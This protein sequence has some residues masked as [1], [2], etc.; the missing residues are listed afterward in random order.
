MRSL[1]ILTFVVIALGLPF[2]SGQTPTSEVSVVATAGEDKPAAVPPLPA[3][4]AAKL[5]ARVEKMEKDFEQQKR[6]VLTSAIARLSTAAGSDLAA[7]DLYLGCRRILAARSAAAQEAIATKKPD[8]KDA[9]AMDKREEQLRD[10]LEEPGHG[11]VLRLQAEYLM[12]TLEAPAAKD[13]AALVGRVR[14]FVNKAMGI[15]RLSISAPMAAGGNKVVA[16][17]NSKGKNRDQDKDQQLQAEMRAR[18]AIPQQLRQSVLSTVFAQ[19]YNL[20]NYHQKLEGWVNTPLALES[21][22][23]NY[24]MPYY[25]AQRRADLVAVWDEYLNHN[26]TMQRA[27]LDDAPFAR[28]GITEYKQLQWDKWCDLLVYGS[29]PSVAADELASLFHDNPT[30]PQT[31][32]WLENLKALAEPYKPA[33]PAPAEPESPSPAA[34]PTPA[35]GTPEAPFKF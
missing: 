29:N 32:A 21:V 26:L 33:P 5:L 35:L 23:T 27:M 1:P 3:D 13:R 6:E 24:I 9:R 8:P 4:V 22:Y 20:N 17:T 25:R 31:A 19:A 2:A 12:I 11:V 15:I 28:W 30:H 16:T 18:R 34:A 7:I 10:S 14:D